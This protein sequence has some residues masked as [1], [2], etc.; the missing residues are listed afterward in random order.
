MISNLN[1]VIIPQA[2]S[3]RVLG[4]E[5]NILL[6]HPNLFE[7]S[8]KTAFLDPLHEFTQEKKAVIRTSADGDSF[9][10]Y[11]ASLSSGK[12]ITYHKLVRGVTPNASIINLVGKLIYGDIKTMAKSYDL[13]AIKRVPANVREAFESIA[14]AM[15]EITNQLNHEGYETRVAQMKETYRRLMPEG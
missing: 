6:Q 14:S 3:S 13:Q 12:S 7:R 15:N 5:K 2:V 10:A 11:L 1:P 9:F 4:V 8:F